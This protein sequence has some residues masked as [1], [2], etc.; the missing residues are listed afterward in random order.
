VDHCFVKMNRVVHARLL[1]L[2]NAS[3]GLSTDHIHTLHLQLEISR[4]AS[5]ITDD[6]STPSNLRFHLSKLSDERVKKDMCDAFDVGVR[7]RGLMSRAL[8]DPAS[9]DR[10]LV[11]LIQSVCRR[12]LGQRNTSTPA[13]GT[14][15]DIPVG[16]QDPAVST[17]LY[18][19]AAVESRENGVILPSER[20][21]LKGF[22]ALQEISTSLAERYAG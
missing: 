22:S 9:L 5:A 4:S 11:S 21:R 12:F 16:H 15:K 18:K 6:Y 20:G 3:V 17:L 7:S 19:A 10:R 14:P 2:E 1:L 13:T 8:V